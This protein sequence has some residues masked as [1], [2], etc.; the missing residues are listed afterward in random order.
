MG[1]K[2]INLS[3][4]MSTIRLSQM[5]MGNSNGLT[6]N[7]VNVMFGGSFAMTLILAKVESKLL[8]YPYP[9]LSTGL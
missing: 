6:E 9:H 1:Y 4:L 2:P 5:C 3:Q 8:A 7:C